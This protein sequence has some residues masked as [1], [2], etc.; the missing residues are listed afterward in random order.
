MAHFLYRCYPP[1]EQNWEKRYIPENGK[2]CSCCPQM[3]LPCPCETTSCPLVRTPLPPSEPGRVEQLWVETPHLCKTP[4]S[5]SNNWEQ[6]PRCLSP[7][8]IPY[9][10][11]DVAYSGAPPPEFGG[12]GWCCATAEWHQ[13]AQRNLFGDTRLEDEVKS[14]LIPE[15]QCRKFYTDPNLA[16]L[17]IQRRFIFCPIN[18]YNFA[19]TT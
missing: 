18:K 3:L 9:G 8:N 2:G 6:H 11:G 10:H 15:L 13:R 14:G 16:S 17:P 19:I 7:W 12:P 4:H 5:A 1:S